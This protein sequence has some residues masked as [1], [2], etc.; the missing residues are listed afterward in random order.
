[1]PNMMD[2]LDWRGDL[3]FRADPF[4]AVDNLALCEMAYTDFDGIVPCNAEET[5]TL[6]EASRIF[7][8]RYSK[9]ELLAKDSFTKMAPFL[10]EKMALSERFRNMRLFGFVNYVDEKTEAQMAVISCLLGD[11]TVFVAFRGTDESVVGWKE[12]FN[13]SFMT[14]TEGQKRAVQY[15]NSMYSGKRGK[16]RV[17]GHSKGGNFAVYA[18]AFALKGV[19]SRILSVYTN[20]GPGFRPEVTERPSYREMIPKI[21]SIV[22][23]STIVSVLLENEVQHCVVR[24]SAG[25]IMQH[26]ALT[27]Q[28]TG[29]HF[30]PAEERDDTSRFF[31][32]TMRTWLSGLPDGERESFVDSLFAILRSTGA[33][34]IEEIGNDPLRSGADIIRFIRRMPKGEQ[35]EFRS[36]I[37]KLIKSGQNVLTEAV[38]KRFL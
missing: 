38:K 18:S 24:S 20:D 34:K 3:T 32:T 16:I 12:D 15:L 23:E 7:F 27:W 2:Y 37:G 6:E 35:E 36:A 17:G 22:P 5:V 13:L 10:M 11:G 21:V 19:R 9:E 4:N 26:D 1:M 31:D 29:N 8:E 33:E 28:I 25:G 14:E 30:I